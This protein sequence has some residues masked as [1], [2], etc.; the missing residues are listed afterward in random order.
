MAM[1]LCLDSGHLWASPSL[2]WHFNGSSIIHF[3]IHSYTLH[4][5]RVPGTWPD[6]GET[7]MSKTQP[8]PLRSP[9]S[10]GGGGICCHKAGY[11]MCQMTTTS[12]EVPHQNHTDCCARLLASLLQPM[13]NAELASVQLCFPRPHIKTHTIWSS[14]PGQCSSPMVI[15]S[16]FSH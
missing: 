12:S 14:E 9:W 2:G 3:L 5:H 11:N 7:R 15:S 10:S 6:T 13:G 8:L 4:S 16:A 1:T